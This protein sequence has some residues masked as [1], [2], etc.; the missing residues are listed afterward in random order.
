MITA[1]MMIKFKKSIIVSFYIGS[2]KART[3]VMKEEYKSG[4]MLSIS[5]FFEALSAIAGAF[6]ESC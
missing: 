2:G 4:Q 6:R 5:N 3:K 1:T